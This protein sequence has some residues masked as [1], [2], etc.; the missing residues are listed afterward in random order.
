MCD[1]IAPK[2]TY[3]CAVHIDKG[4]EIV[5]LMLSILGDSLPFVIFLLNLQSNTCEIGI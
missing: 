3:S 5:M 4:V 2:G 1:N